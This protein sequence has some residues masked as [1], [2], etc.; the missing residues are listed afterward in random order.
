MHN[1]LLVFALLSATLSALNIATS[2][3]WIEH[4]PQP[5]AIANFY[6]G[7]SR[8]VLTS[9]GVADLG[10]NATYDLAANAETQGLRQY[11]QRRNLR[12]IYIIC[13]VGY[14]L[15]ANKAAGITSLRDLKGKKIGTLPG[16]SAGVF[17]AKMLASVGL[18]E[19]DVSLV[20]GNVCMKTPCAANTFPAQLARRDID[21]FGVWEPAVELGIRALGAGNAAVFQNASLYREVYSLYATT[22]ALGNAAKRKDIVAFVRALEKTRE[23]FAAPT[24]TVFEFVGREVGVERGVVEALVEFLVEEDAYLAGRDKR[25]KVAKKDLERFLDGSVLEELRGGSV[26]N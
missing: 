14:R 13:E 22:E 25:I 4:T 20:S 11:A 3:Q 1:S 19:S 8:A 7:S 9:G 18:K 2:L 12:L 15:V 17:V 21:A 10:T 5:Y 16:T 24:S 23:V 6:N 26:G